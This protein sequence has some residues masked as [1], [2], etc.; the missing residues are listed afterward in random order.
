ML[1]FL[2]RKKS[3]MKVLEKI[4][5]ALKNTGTVHKP[6]VNEGTKVLNISRNKRTQKS[7][8]KNIAH[9]NNAVSI[10]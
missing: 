7:T 4:I 5:S 8:V 9:H 3:I 10:I 2:L 1:F 6:E